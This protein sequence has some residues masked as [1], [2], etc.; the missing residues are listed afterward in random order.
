MLPML[1]NW[2]QIRNNMKPS[3]NIG[4]IWVTTKFSIG[5]FTFCFEKLKKKKKNALLDIETS[6]VKE[7]LW[8]CRIKH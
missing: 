1:S 7:K 8:T 5:I 4:L 6:N 3:R 2:V